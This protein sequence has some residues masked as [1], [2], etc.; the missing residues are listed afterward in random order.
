MNILCNMCDSVMRIHENAC[1]HPIVV[2]KAFNPDNPEIAKMICGTIVIL[3]IIA[4]LT[5]LLWK[6]ISF[7]SEADKAKRERVNALEDGKRKQIA[8]YQRRTLDLLANDKVEGL[9]RL[10]NYI[11]DLKNEEKEP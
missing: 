5:I 2:E 11:N 8:E 9:E 6:L 10:K 1:H 7:W 4:A 3:A